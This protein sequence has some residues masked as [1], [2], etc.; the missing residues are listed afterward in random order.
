MSRVGTL[1]ALGGAI[2]IVSG[3]A[4]DVPPGPHD[5]KECTRIVKIKT[6][7]T[8]YVQDNA[9]ATSHVRYLGISRDRERSS[10][11]EPF[12]PCN[13]DVSG[14]KTRTIVPSITSRQKNSASDATTLSSRQSDRF[15]ATICVCAT[16]ATAHAH[17][18]PSIPLHRLLRLSILPKILEP[19][20]RELGV[21]HRVHDVLVA[22]VVLQRARVASV[23]RELV[24]GRVPQ[25]VRMHAERKLRSAHQA[26]RATCGS[27]P[28]SSA[29]RARS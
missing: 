6:C 9:C 17:R 23:V 12:M 13:H 24:A 19:L 16:K 21:A 20:R 18:A 2:F 4:Y 22:E 26:A 10:R 8:T 28:A 15:G 1:C 5:S 7:Q 14:S 3:C 25:H 29:R 11:S 27:P